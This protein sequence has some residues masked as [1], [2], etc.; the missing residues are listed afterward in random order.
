M[1]ISY[2]IDFKLKM[3]KREKD[4]QNYIA[5]AK[6]IKGTQMRLLKKRGHYNWYNRNIKDNKRLLWNAIHQQIG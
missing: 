6:L 2:K 4:K 5:L 3:F 1:L